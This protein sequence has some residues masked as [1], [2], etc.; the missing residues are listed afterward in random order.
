MPMAIEMARA[1]C[2]KLGTVIAWASAAAVLLA[3]LG[4]QSRGASLA[5]AASL[6]FLWLYSS[7]KAQSLL[8]ILIVGSCILAY[9]S[10]VYLKR[11][12]TIAHYEQDSSAEARIKA[13]KMSIR[14]FS[15]SVDWRRYRTISFGL[16]QNS[17]P[18]GRWRTM[19]DGTLHVLPDPR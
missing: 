14:M 1:S 3:V 6:G 11:M 13:W 9:S 7:K 4:T 8:V 16:R 19:D 17:P 5:L 18:G 15:E 10:D 12:S 2:S